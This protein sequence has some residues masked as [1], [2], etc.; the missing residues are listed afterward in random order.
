MSF[1]AVP[2]GRAGL[3]RAGQG[4]GRRGGGTAPE[5]ALP[6]TGARG[7]PHLAEVPSPSRQ[8]RLACQSLGRRQR[9]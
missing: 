9:L 3:G 7:S 5:T 8:G 4:Q 6:E 2:L 1:R